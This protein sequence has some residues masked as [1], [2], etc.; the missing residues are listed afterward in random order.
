MKHLILVWIGMLFY[1][2][3][4]Q[5]QQTRPTT[6]RTPA[7]AV[8]SDIR[9][10]QAEANRT[11]KQIHDIEHAGDKIAITY[12]RTPNGEYIFT[13][14]NNSYAN[15]VVELSFPTLENLRSDVPVP[16][17]MDV[18]PG[19]RRMVTLGIVTKGVAVHFNHRFRYFKGYL[20]DKKVDTA[21]T[22]LLPI[23][24]G[25]E[26]HIYELNYIASEFNN[27][28]QPKGWYALSLHVHSGDTIYAARRGIVTETRDDA[29]LQ[30]SGYT[31]AGKDNYVEVSHEDCTFGRYTAFRDSS[32]FVKPG[33]FVEAGQP[34]GIAGGDKYAGGPQVR[35]AVYYHLEQEIQV[36]GEPKTIYLAYIPLKF[37]TKHQG[38]IHLTNHSKYVSEHPSSLITKEMS[39]KEAK[40]WEEN[41]KA[42]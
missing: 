25:R 34:I 4:S 40:K 13:C 39:K 24:P 26:T 36:N 29:E 16:Y 31:F 2:L 23:P 27:Q 30:D 20:S 32:I 10:E 9:R 42:G 22:Y 28:P 5:A 8:G 1:T 21:Y 15:Y 11:A 37:W 17:R 12:D 14:H 18:P 19:T 41:H 33:E 3:S 35:F 7:H 38:S 6:S